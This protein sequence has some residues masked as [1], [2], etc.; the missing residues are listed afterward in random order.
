[1]TAPLSAVTAVQ[2]AVT[3][4][5]GAVTATQ[6]AVTAVQR[7]TTATKGATTAAHRAVTATEG[8][9][10]ATQRAMTATK[11]AVVQRSGGTTPARLRTT[12]KRVGDAAGCRA[13]LRRTRAIDTEGPWAAW[14]RAGSAPGPLPAAHPA[15]RE[16]GAE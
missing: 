14:N 11:S 7:A 16:R 6:R 12:R 8:A 2:R 13:D 9:T 15:P 4:A 3:A 10:T 5:K 1:M